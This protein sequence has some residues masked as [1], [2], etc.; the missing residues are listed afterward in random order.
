MK[1]LVFKKMTE[2]EEIHKNAHMDIDSDSKHR[3][4]SD[5]IDSGSLLSF[6]SLIL[7]RFFFFHN[8]IVTGLDVTSG[9]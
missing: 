6:I 4:F 8:K 1:E 7:F 3:V 5:L 9:H 2:L